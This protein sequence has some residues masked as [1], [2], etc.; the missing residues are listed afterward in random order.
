[1]NT[2]RLSQ[3]N[4]PALAEGD[5]WALLQSPDHTMDIQRLEIRRLLKIVLQRV[6]VPSYIGTVLWYMTDY[7]GI[8]V[9]GVSLSLI[10]AIVYYPLL[11]P[12]LAVLDEELE[13][14]RTKAQAQRRTQFCETFLPFFHAYKNVLSKYPPALLSDSAAGV[15]AQLE[16]FIH[17]L[18]QVK[19]QRLTETANPYEAVQALLLTPRDF[20]QWEF[21][22]CKTWQANLL[23]A[24]A[25][26]RIT[27]LRRA[28]QY[29]ARRPTRHGWETFLA[30]AEGELD[31]E[32]AH[33]I[34]RWRCVQRAHADPEV[35][36]RLATLLRLDSFHRQAGLQPYL[37]S[38][39]LQCSPHEVQTVMEYIR[40]EPVAATVLALVEAPPAP[41]PHHKRDSTSLPQS[42]TPQDD[43]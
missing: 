18:C 8:M 43:T 12:V 26:G 32:A 42:P 22:A 4:A 15:A 21:Q 29:F 23:E 40:Y 37:L 39:S 14:H 9:G 33:T 25:R 35:R 1:L 41:L 20:H 38:G 17:S 13:S 2:R 10:L 19:G 6:L 24:L 30:R 36:Q 11:R 28:V 16:S 31:R 3:R 5:V 27:T 7:F 34:S